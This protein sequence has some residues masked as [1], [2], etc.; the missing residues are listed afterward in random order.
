MSDISARPARALAVALAVIAAG[1]L[2]GCAATSQGGQ[3]DENGTPVWLNA[4]AD[5]EDAF[6]T[7]Q[8][9][10]AK[11]GRA[12]TE[13]SRDRF[14]IDF[15]C[16]EP[17]SLRRIVQTKTIDAATL[18]DIKSAPQVHAVHYQRPP[19][20][21]DPPRNPRA[22]VNP[23]M[24]NS[25]VPSG[26]LLA[27]LVGAAI[28]GASISRQRAEADQY[29][30]HLQASEQRGARL[31]EDHALTDP[32]LMVKAEVLRDLRKAGLANIREVAE[33]FDGWVGD[34]R[35]ASKIREGIVLEFGTQDWTL[36]TSTRTLDFVAFGKLRQM[37]ADSPLWAA[38]CHLPQQVLPAVAGPR[39][40]GGGLGA[41][42]QSNL[43]DLAKA[44]AAG[45][46]ESLLQSGNSQ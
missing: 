28:D 19:L 34:A 4:I 11:H 10:C 17:S 20:R 46:A 16:V 29:G 2:P 38:E 37:D 12:A 39:A 23:G 3:G 22:V 45:L 43:A 14:R 42:L 15:A 9:H 27:L 40:E 7:A 24:A 31:L 25:A 5:R 41:A 13:K 26:G 6:R 33:P 18:A 30:P 44:C 36:R 35:M 1:L 21:V 32:I 8:E